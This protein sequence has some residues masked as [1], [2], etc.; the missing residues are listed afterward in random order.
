MKGRVPTFS[1]DVDG[2][3]LDVTGR[4]CEEVDAAQDEGLRPGPA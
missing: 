4:F 3:V 1:E 2:V